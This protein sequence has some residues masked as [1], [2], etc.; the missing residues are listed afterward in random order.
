MYI[1]YLKLFP[2]FATRFFL[3]GGCDGSAA[4]TPKKEKSSNMPL[5]KG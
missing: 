1:F 2:A 3:F 4:A 5:N